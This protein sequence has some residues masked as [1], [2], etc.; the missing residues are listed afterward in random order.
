V[1]LAKVSAKILELQVVGTASMGPAVAVPTREG[2]ICMEV[3]TMEFAYKGVFRC[4]VCGCGITVEI[5]KGKYVYYHCTGRRGLCAGQKA[6]RE[7]SITDQLADLLK[8]LKIEAEVETWLREA[9]RESFNEERGARDEQVK[10]LET[11]RQ[12]LRGKLQRL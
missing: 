12:T 3:E 10:R 5:K 4:G 1:W 2:I 6:V 7:E 9:L 8:G 11:E